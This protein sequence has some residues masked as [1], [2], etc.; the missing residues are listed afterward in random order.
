M[1]F[2]VLA[3]FLLDHLI[4]HLVLHLKLRDVGAAILI[5]WLSPG[6]YLYLML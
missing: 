1:A 2:I 4:L 6:H 3:G 5:E